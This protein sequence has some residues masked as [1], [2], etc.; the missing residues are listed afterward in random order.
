[1]DAKYLAQCAKVHAEIIR[2]NLQRHAKFDALTVEQF[3]QIYNGIGPD[4]WPTELREVMTAIYYDFAELPGVHDV[5][6]FFSDGTREGWQATQDRWLWNGKKV[7]N[8]RY[9]LWQFW[10]YKLRA[11]AWA[12]VL[13]SYEVLKLASF[14]V[15]QSAVKR[16]A[17]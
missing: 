8:A 12:K 14:P 3:A 4:S 1:M 11:I 9:P 5:D 2:L 15:Y 7:L 10:N 17:I 6:Y 13:S 16:F